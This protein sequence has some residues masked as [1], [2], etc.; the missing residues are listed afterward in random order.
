[1]HASACVHVC[2]VCAF[3]EGSPCVAVSSP[4]VSMLQIVELHVQVVASKTSSGQEPLNLGGL[5]WEAQPVEL[6]AC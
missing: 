2:V 5:G 4:P 6:L 1:M 3:V